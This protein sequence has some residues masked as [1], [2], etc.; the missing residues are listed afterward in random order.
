MSWGNGEP[1]WHGKT[2]NALKDNLTGINKEE[3]NGP[4][5]EAS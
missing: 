2:H 4:N 5:F 3:V 1:D